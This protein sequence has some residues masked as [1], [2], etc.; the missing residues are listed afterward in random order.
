MQREWDTLAAGNSV[1]SATAMQTNLANASI[2]AEKL[3]PKKTS[4]ASII[5]MLHRQEI[6][7]WNA[8][9]YHFVHR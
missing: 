9:S 1:M 7:L 4:S 3:K 2:K 5:I 8:V 6:R